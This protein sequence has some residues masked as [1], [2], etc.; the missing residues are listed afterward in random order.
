LIVGV[1]SLVLNFLLS[2]E[3]RVEYVKEVLIS[4][5]L[6]GLDS[7]S[8]V[9]IKGTVFLLARI[10]FIAHAIIYLLLGIRLA[11]K[12]N[13]RINEF[14]SNTEGRRLNWV[15]N[16]SI[17]ILVVSFAGIA[18]S[19]IGRSYFA[20]KPLA[21]LIPSLLFSTIYFLIGFHANQQKVVTEVMEEIPAE[22]AI[23]NHVSENGQEKKLKTKLLNLFEND[24]IYTQTDLRITTLSELLQ[25][26]RT[27]I[28]RLINAEF[29]MNFNEFVNQYRVREAEKLLSSEAHDSYTLDYIAEEVGFGNGNSFARAF[30]EYKG[31][32]PGQFRK[33]NVG[34]KIA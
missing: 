4:R 28:S 14:F 20:H 30:K 22:K 24:K 23:E 9:G 15:R 26:N 19:L 13:R 2:P 3:Q 11:N 33:N 18:L 10:I 6:K 7:L 34:E 25:T 12:H 17:I 5:N 29:G 16:I 21:L 27:Y 8:I 32:T 31:V 1:V